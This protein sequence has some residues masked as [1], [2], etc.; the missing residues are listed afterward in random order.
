MWGARDGECP[1][2][3]PFPGYNLF[4][5]M[6]ILQIIFALTRIVMNTIS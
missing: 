3:P 6:V 4:K 5:E 2:T 1:D